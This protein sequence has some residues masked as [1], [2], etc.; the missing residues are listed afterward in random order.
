[1][2]FKVLQIFSAKDALIKLSQES[3]PIKASFRIA[4]FIDAIKPTLTVVD[5]QRNDLIL[6]YGQEIEDENGQKIFSIR[7]EESIQK[8]SEEF[9]EV[10]EEEVEISDFKPVTLND[11]E[12]VKMTPLEVSVLEPF[13]EFDIE[14]D[15]EP[16]KEEK[17]LQ[18]KLK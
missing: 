16:K 18:E 6:K 11:I 14:E 13:I 1:M 10:L 4:K 12:N 7:D 3:L 8:F 9:N 17:T 5:K 15:D 2:K